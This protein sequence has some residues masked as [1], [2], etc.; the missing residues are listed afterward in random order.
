MQRVKLL[1]RNLI[2]KIAAGEVLERPSSAV[3]ELVENSLDARSNKIHVFVRN[4]GK[5]EIK[6]IDNGT[7]MSKDDLKMSIMRHATSKFNHE[8]FSKIKTH[9]FRGEA[10][11][12]IGSV[13]KMNII[14]KTEMSEDGFEINV[15]SGDISTVKPSARN[16]GTTVTIK[17][18]FF[19][20]P[21]RLKFLKSEKYENF[22]IKKLIQK[23]AICN[24][25]VS[26]QLHINDKLI[27]KTNRPK[28]QI[29]MANLKSRISEC[30]GANF[31][32][33]LRNI[34]S[35]HEGYKLFGYIGIPTFNHSNNSNQFIFVNGRIVN[36][37][38]LNNAIKYAYR[39]FIA[40]DRHSQLVL[41]INIA[42]DEVDI[43]VHPAKSEVRFKDINSL[44]K[45]L[46]RSIKDTLKNIGYE[47]ST[48]NKR[49]LIQKFKPNYDLDFDILQKKFSSVEEENLNLNDSSKIITKNQEKFNESYSI[50]PLGF[51]K[52]Q[53]YNT[54]IISQTNEGLIIIDQHAAH[55]RII[56]EKIKKQ[57]YEKQFK[58]QVLL[59]PEVIK[60][61]SL[62]IDILSKNIEKLRGFG[63]V[64]EEFG[65]DSLIVREIPMILNKCNIKKLIKDVI[66]EIKENNSDEILEKNIN[67]ICSVMSCHGS[68][69]AGR[70]LEI[71]EMNSL[72]RE[73][74]S[75]PYSAQCNHGRPTFIKLDLKDIEKLFGRN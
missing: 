36:D 46:V 6:V 72:L 75:T 32:D 28:L 1:T 25:N 53:L 43:N 52:C 8:N 42:G 63:I 38:I 16:T 59:I 11:P 51:A 18:I 24:F 64:I 29:D 70:K 15:N 61:E 31:S 35:M 33:N 39:D 66:E 37:K 26:F 2:N 69:R 74:E 60:I 19:S 34:S 3:K 48:I 22:L 41:F 56:Y 21:A 65:Q 13:A 23:L 4:G 67:G 45:F 73:M 55:E 10:L 9:G 50:F 14:S 12:A 57:F 68:I 54:F 5:T 58:T 71:E 49:D 47:S 17:D 30:L 44:R 7:G 40:Y 20:T 62:L 27:L